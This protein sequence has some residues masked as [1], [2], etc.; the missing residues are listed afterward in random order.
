MEQPPPVPPLCN[1]NI[2]DD[3]LTTPSEATGDLNCQKTTTCTRHPVYR[4]V[5]KRWWGKW[6]SE[7]REPR[8]KSRIGLGSFTAPEMAV[9]AYGVAAYCLKGRKALLNFPDEI[10]LLPRPSSCAARDIQAAAALAAKA[11]VVAE[12]KKKGSMSSESDQYDDDFWGEIELPE[13]NESTKKLWNNNHERFV[14]LVAVEMVLRM[15]SHSRSAVGRKIRT[16]QP[17]YRDA[18][19]RRDHRGFSQ[20]DLCKNCKRPGHY[21]RE[22]PN[23]AICHNCGFPE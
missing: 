2:E 7:I 6:V 17:S 11:A 14:L 1:N 12:K 4:G 15:S 9:R 23:V 10:K 22:C 21:A 20:S 8:K 19:Y 13:L 5:H 3:D 18:P 16:E